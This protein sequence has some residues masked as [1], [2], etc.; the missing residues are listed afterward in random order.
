MKTQELLPSDLKINSALLFKLDK[1]FDFWFCFVVCYFFSFKCQKLFFFCSLPDEVH[2]QQSLSGRDGLPG[3]NGLV[4][5]ADALVVGSHFST[6]HP[7]RFAED[8]GVSL[9]HL[10]DLDVRA[11]QRKMREGERE[12][13]N[14]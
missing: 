14:T 4:P 5:D 1:P 10:R 13:V 3:P 12:L 2:A 7:G 11:L 6:P 8:D 9:L